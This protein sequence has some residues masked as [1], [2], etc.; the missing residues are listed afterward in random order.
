M[1]RFSWCSDCIEAIF[2]VLETFLKTFPGRW[3][4][5]HCVKETFERFF[6]CWRLPH[7]PGDTL[8][9]IFAVLE[10]S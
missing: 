1:E 8:V 2:T 9:T 5:P 4:F 3:G 7:H 6:W 10:T